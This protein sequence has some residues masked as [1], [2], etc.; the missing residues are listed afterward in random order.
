MQDKN[1]KG[2]MVC[3]HQLAQ[4][5]WYGMHARKAPAT[6]AVIIDVTVKW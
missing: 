5:P 4:Q 2:R 3:V 1:K 6:L